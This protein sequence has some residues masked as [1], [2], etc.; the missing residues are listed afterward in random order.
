MS[1]VTNS[2]KAREPQRETSADP[3]MEEILASIRRI[4]ADD[5]AL[6]L[7]QRDEP[8][9]M[10][11]AASAAPSTAGVERRVPKPVGSPAVPHT[12]E[13]GGDFEAWLS[14]T[15]RRARSDEPVG[16]SAEQPTAVGNSAPAAKAPTEQ[17]NADTVA[18]EPT[19]PKM[20]AASQT[21]DE[22][23]LQQDDNK[24]I[25]AADTSES[26]EHDTTDTDDWQPSGLSIV[27]DDARADD[28]EMVLDAEDDELEMPVS[29]AMQD[30][31][32]LLSGSA[33]SSIST[34]FQA[35]TQSVMLQN[36]ALIEKEIRG[37]LRPMLKQWL[38]DNLPTMVERLVRAEIER[39]ARGGP[40]NQ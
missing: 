12:A 8:V 2:A 6:P 31:S 33:S 3:S 10:A 24:N 13:S 35:L 23:D 28:D 21:D 29:N 19:I 30:T 25:Q 32:D 20:P 36:T 18:G 4:I 14:E 16:K 26:E 11:R 27:E 17:A 34:S 37:L 1:A 22:S 5:Q 9:Q 39:V 15:A 7:T 40:G 38:D